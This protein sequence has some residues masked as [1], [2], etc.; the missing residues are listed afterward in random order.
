[1]ALGILEGIAHLNRVVMPEV[2][3]ITTVFLK[4]VEICLQA[5]VRLFLRSCT[6]FYSLQSSPS[7]F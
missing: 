2:M 5:M 4:P 1:M 3:T 6:F 7:C